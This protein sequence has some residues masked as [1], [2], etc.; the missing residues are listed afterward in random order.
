MG[1]DETARSLVDELIRVQG[2]GVAA[3]ATLG[4]HATSLYRWRS[5]EYMLHGPALVAIRAVLAHPEDFTKYTELVRPA[6]RP[7]PEDG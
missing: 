4:V 3:A 6:H 5:G 7:K 2:N 1:P